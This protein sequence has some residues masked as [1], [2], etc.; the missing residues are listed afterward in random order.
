ML[1][2][3]ALPD[4]ANFHHLQSLH[5]DSKCPPQ[6]RDL[7]AYRTLKKF[8]SIDAPTSEKNSAS[9]FNPYLDVSHPHSFLI[10]LPHVPEYKYTKPPVLAIASLHFFKPFPRCILH[11]RI[12]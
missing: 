3:P 7:T 9:P 12:N 11:K 2:R 8:V 10:Q 4:R 1:C 5:V 6:Q